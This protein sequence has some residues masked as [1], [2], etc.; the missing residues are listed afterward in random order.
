L[1]RRINQRHW[2]PGELIPREE[3]LAGEFGCARATVNRA[4]RDLA[5]AGLIERRRKAGSRVR[6]APERKA[7]LSI[8]VI[9]L[10]VESRGQ[11]YR[12]ALLERQLARPP[13]P[14]AGRMGLLRASPLLHLRTL[15]FAAN[16]PYAYEDRW[17]NPAAAPEAS[18][19]DFAAISANEW[20]VR[21]SPFTAGDIA[22]SA[23]NASDEVAE[24]LGVQRGVAIFVVDR[25]TWNLAL[26]VTSVRLFYAPGYSVSTT[27]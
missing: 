3:E 24:C 9:R 23:A 15:H 13:S 14:V 8:P 7:T 5:D 10:E 19:T 21:N 1:L 4:M 6:P 22:F 11:A 18:N 26:P 16:R 17:L 25:I 12:H 20:L 2:H 27:L